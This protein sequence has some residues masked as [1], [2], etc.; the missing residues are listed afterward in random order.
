MNAGNLYGAKN[1]ALL[2]IWNSKCKDV[3]KDVQR[4]FTIWRDAT[5]FDKLRKMRV[6]RLV[7]KCYNNKLAQAWQMWNN[8][9]QELNYQVR[10]H[11]CAMEFAER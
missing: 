11:I 9:S 1:K 5:N 7:W 8:Y 4:A 3:K 10:L 2:A 6:K